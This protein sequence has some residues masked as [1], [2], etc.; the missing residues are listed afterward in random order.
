MRLKGKGFTLI[1][2]LVVIA[3]I[4]VLA[5]ILF[6]VFSK[7]R[8]KSKTSVCQSNMKQISL[9]LMMYVSDYEGIFPAQP[10][11]DPDTPMVIKGGGGVA[12]WKDPAVYPNWARSIEPYIKNAQIP[13]CPLSKKMSSCRQNCG[14][15]FTSK[16]YPLSLFGNGKVF[17]YG[18][19]ESGIT[20]SSD[21]VALICCGQTWSSCFIAPYLN[22]SGQWVSFID[23]D[24]C[25]HNGGTNIIFTDGHLKWMKYESIA[26][27]L[28][29]YEP[30]KA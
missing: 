24:W 11:D 28:S 27:D 18:I 9:G 7:A 4:A 6:P 14:M 23:K 5:A 2:L 10:Y 8:D 30:V 19:S 29:I 25:W 15:T 20:S 1:E 12:N 17:K 13:N 26:S 16:A 22:T 21:T 3:I